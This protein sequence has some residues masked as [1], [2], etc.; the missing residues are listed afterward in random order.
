MRRTWMGIAAVALA[1]MLV[2]PAFISTVTAASVEAS[3][4][5]STVWLCRPG[6][7]NDPCTISLKTTTVTATGKTSVTTP[8]AATPARFACFYVYGTVSEE[9][10]VNADLKDGKAEIASAEAQGAP[11]SPLCQVYAP[12]YRQV[13]LADLV[14]HPG[15][16]FG[17]AESVTAYDS[18]RSGF[19]N[20]L[21]HDLDRR[22]F[23]VIGD[24]QGAAMLDLLLAHFVE[25]DA[26]LRSKLVAA[27]ILGGNVEVPTGK[28]EGGMFQHIPACNRFGE[29]GCVIA[30][31]S[32][33][34]T[35]PADALFGR[36]GQGVSLQSGQ[37][38]KK[39][40]SVVCVNPAA[41][42]NASATLDSIFPVPNANP[43]PWVAYPGRYRASCEDEDGATW[44]EVTKA[45]GNTDHRPTPVSEDD[46][47]QYGY[48]VFDFPL[49][50][51]NLLA[52][53]GA[54]EHTWTKEHQ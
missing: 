44:L 25:N 3:S 39:G 11:F 7:A 47:S 52:D 41:F 54:A 30:Y 9:Q 33:P 13:T 19:E 20:F 26:S 10:S 45:T 38:A 21:D 23:V 36:P 2:S 12:I 6:M 16:N 22:P 32:F 40:L 43:T 34:S 46:G 28:L 42:S 37:T 24:S 1:A 15:L 31:S 50:E 5:A 48:H 14:A 17:T 29:S 4:T 8:T 27:I 51:G 18:I 53:V 35:P 49:A